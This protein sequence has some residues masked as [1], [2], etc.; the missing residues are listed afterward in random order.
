MELLH[1]LLSD[2]LFDL[3]VLTGYLMLPKQRIMVDDP[4][5]HVL[6]GGFIPPV[7]TTWHRLKEIFNLTVCTGFE[8][9]ITYLEPDNFVNI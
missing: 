9:N 1:L 5:F 6:W 7:V 4:F 3:W 2:V 8:D